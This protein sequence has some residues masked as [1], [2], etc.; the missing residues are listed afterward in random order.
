[1]QGI[2]KHNLK[3]HPLTDPTR[4]PHRASTRSSPAYEPAVRLP[5]Q[6]QRRGA[7]AVVE[8][9]VGGKV[10]HIRLPGG[11]DRGGV[12]VHIV[13]LLRDIALNVENELLARL[14]ILRSS[15][16]LKHGRKRGVMDV[17]DV[18]G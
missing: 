11:R 6:P 2:G 15:L 13:L 9:V 1:M 3:G 4:S 5:L 16:F 12:Q 10:L 14:Q 7:I 17:A 8:A 18:P